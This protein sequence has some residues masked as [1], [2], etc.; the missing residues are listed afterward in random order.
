[1]KTLRQVCAATILS[2]MIIVSAWAGDLHA[3]GKASTGTNTT[4]GTSTT[5]VTTSVILTIVHSDLP[6]KGALSNV[7]ENA[8][9]WRVG[10]DLSNKVLVRES[11]NL[12]VACGVVGVDWWQ[13]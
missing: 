6:L 11:E 9:H 10:K 4:T 5:S 3:P 12:I 7:L 13:I 8:S 1:M 2:L